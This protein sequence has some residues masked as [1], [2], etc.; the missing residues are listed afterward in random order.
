MIKAI[1]PFE[2]LLNWPTVIKIPTIVN[3]SEIAMLRVGLFLKNIQD[4]R[5]TIRGLQYQ[6]TIAKPVSIDS[7]AKK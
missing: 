3:T 7:I 6:S 4:I 1:A 2:P 5:T